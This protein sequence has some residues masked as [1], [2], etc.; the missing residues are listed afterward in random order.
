[1]K[2]NARLGL[3]MDYAIGQ[4]HPQTNHNEQK[5]KPFLASNRSSNQNGSQMQH[6]QQ[7]DWTAQVQQFQRYLQWQKYQVMRN[8]KL[9]I[10]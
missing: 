8:N 6:I 1:M 10:N 4:Q 2:D 9:I 7:P 3:E 5:S